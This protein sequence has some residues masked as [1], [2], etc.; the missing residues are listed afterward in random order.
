MRPFT[1]ISIDLFYLPESRDG[2]KYVI[3]AMDSFTKWPEGTAL[4]DR[5]SRTMAEWLHREVVCRYGAPSVVRTDNGGEFMGLFHAY[6]VNNS[7][8]HVVG[9]PYYP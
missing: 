1:Y 9:S 4:H 8:L 6:L 5:D 3:V 7:I 2:Y